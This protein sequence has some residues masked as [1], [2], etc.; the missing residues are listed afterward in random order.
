MQRSVFEG[1]IAGLNERGFDLPLLALLRSHG[2]YD[3]HFTHGQYEFGKDFIAKRVEG[4]RVVQYAFQSKA[5]DIGGGEWEAIF[6][7]L[8]EAA[9]GSL[10]HPNFDASAFR[11]CVLVTT[12]R[13]KGKAFH[14]ANNFKSTVASQAEFVVWDAD[15][16]LDLAR[17]TNPDFPLRDL[18]P[19]IEHIVAEIQLGS[20][21]SR[22]LLLGLERAA[23]PLPLQR[24][25]LHTASMESTL[26]IAALRRAGMHL[27]VPLVAAHLAR[28]AAASSDA[29]SAG[30]AYEEAT[31]LLRAAVDELLHM[32][33]SA[34]DSPQDFI[35]VVG[36]MFEQWFTYPAACGFLGEFVAIALLHARRVGDRSAVTRYADALLRLVRVQP[37]ARHPASERFAVSTLAMS[38][39]LACLGEWDALE[40]IIVE[41]TNWLC[42][43]LEDDGVGLAGPYADPR[44]EVENL[45]GACLDSVSLER[46]GESLLAVVLVEVAGEWL[47]KMYAD[48]VNDLLAVECC[49]TAVIPVELP[50]ALFLNGGGTRMLMNAVYPPVPSRL[51]WHDQEGWAFAPAIVDAAEAPLLFA[52]AC[53]DRLF[54]AAVFRAVRSLT[55]SAGGV[56]DE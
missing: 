44:R 40:A 52:S 26:V 24:S 51:P 1:W 7:Q 50:G 49:P 16:L 22:T 33:D 8:F 34:L 37:G 45:M 53:R 36:G 19:S 10:V 30:V 28:L 15:Y 3:V 55:A 27:H 12:G 32:F 29:E 11:R 13:L 47:P 21:G 41:V 9:G 18:H 23:P 31:G 48:V 35:D 56:G 20:L 46:Q 2:F 38:A 43:H 17:G 42:D 39:G 14:S 25:E 5:G 6:A 54:Q 4:D